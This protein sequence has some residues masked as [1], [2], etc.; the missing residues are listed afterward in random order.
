MEAFA[1][2]SKLV[3]DHDHDL[4]DVPLHPAFAK[5]KWNY[6]WLNHTAPQPLGRGRDGFWEAAN[7]VVWDLMLPSLKMCSLIL[8]N[9]QTWAW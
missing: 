6:N 9:A 1:P 7:P 4:S 5:D 8:T 3:Q 2:L